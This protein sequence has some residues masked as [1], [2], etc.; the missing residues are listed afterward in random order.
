MGYAWA[1][2]AF[3]FIGHYMLPVRFSG[4]KGFS[5][6]HLTGWGMVVF[7]LFRLD[8]IEAVWAHPGWFWAALIS[9]MLW[10]G[11]QATANLALEEISVAQ[12]SVFF[13][14]NTLLNILAGLAVFHEAKGLKSLLFLFGGSALLIAGALWVSTI[15]SHPTKTHDLR[16]GVLLSF[17]AGSFWGIYF[18]PVVR[19][20]KLD[21]QPLLGPL[22]IMSVMVLGAALVALSLPLMHKTQKMN[23][24]DLSL[25]MISTTSW[26]LGMAG[27]LMSIHLLGLSRAVPIVNSSSLI[28]AA[29]SLFIFKEMPF[30]EWPKVLGSALVALAGGILLALSD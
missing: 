21:P 15:A 30:S 4:A 22:D 26:V 28:A 9:G 11:G 25:G 1:L 23:L 8:S 16:K 24:R 29:W 13:N 19:V 27:L 7:V 3:F 18:I 2:L 17:L 20:Q 14:F 6:F 12:A 10:A 5:F